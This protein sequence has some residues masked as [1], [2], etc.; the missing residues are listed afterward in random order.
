MSEAVKL[1]MGCMNPMGHD[2]ICAGCGYN[3]NN[4]PYNPKYL[5]PGTI[6]SSRYLI[7]KVF[8]FNG[9][10]ATYIAYDKFKD[11]KIF[12]KE[13]MPDSLC[14][15]VIGSSIISVKSASI[16]Q[17]KSYLSE[18]IDLNRKLSKMKALM[19]INP[20]VEIFEV[21]NT[22]YAVL[23]YIDG[24]TLKHFLQ[25]NAGELT[26][27]LVRKLFPPIFTTL[28]LVHNAGL[29]HRG[30][31][32]DTIYY[33]KKGEMKLTGFAVAATRT[34]NTD[35]SAYLFTGYAAPEQYSVRKWQGTWTDVYA[36]SA[37]LYR[38]LTGCMLTDSAE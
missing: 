27:G 38:I 25:D 24:I 2:G 26:W 21:N 34:V 36:V 5:S 7:G 31:S 15:R 11:E 35:L 1:C 19:H 8:S 32:L 3:N 33:T 6:L 16:V 13:F 17:Y 14:E 29:V 4:T 12:I 10:G 22:A 23:E 28:S 37:L 18:F 30:I 9:E 20:A